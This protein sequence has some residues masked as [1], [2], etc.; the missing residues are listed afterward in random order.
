M[1]DK[2]ITQQKIQY[3][4]QGCKLPAAISKYDQL[5]SENTLKYLKIKIIT[6]KK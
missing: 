4:C 6:I 1:I 2:V 3:T 5:G